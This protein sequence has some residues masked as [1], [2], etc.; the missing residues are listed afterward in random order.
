MANFEDITLTEQSP[1]MEPKPGCLVYYLTP[2]RGLNYLLQDPIRGIIYMFI[3][4]F[5][6]TWFAKVWLDVAGIAPRDV[7]HQILRAG[8][9]VPGFRPSPKILERILDRY[10]PTVTIIGG[11]CVGVV[12]AFADFLGSLGTGMGVLLTVGIIYQ[13]YQIIAQEQMADMHPAM[14][15]LLGLES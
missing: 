8:L 4:I 5:L 1:F 9:M 7:S 11:I 15:G 10:I 13:Y 12:A 14:K 6:C 3:L 2:P